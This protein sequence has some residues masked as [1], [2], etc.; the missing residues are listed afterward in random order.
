MMRVEHIKPKMRARVYFALIAAILVALLTAVV[1]AVCMRVRPADAAGTAKIT[2][3][4]Y[5]PEHHYNVAGWIWM[6]SLDGAEYKISETAAAGEQFIKT[7]TYNNK[8]ETNVARTMTVNVTE[9]QRIALN[10]GS[11]EL[12]MLICGATG[13]TQGEFWTRYQKETGDVTVNLKSLFGGNE[14]HVYYIRR[15]ST[16]YT[17]IEEAKN[18]LNRVIGV[19]FTKLTASSTRIEFESAIPLVGT[20]VSVYKGNTEL[21][22]AV[23]EQRGEENARAMPNLTRSTAGTSILPPITY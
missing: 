15:D 2:I 17:D 10:D 22:T 14:A 1:T 19:R 13:A 16:V 8:P 3:H 6:P 12:G 20:Q 7:Y 23:A 21:G 9:A 11:A 18:A 4:I 5:D